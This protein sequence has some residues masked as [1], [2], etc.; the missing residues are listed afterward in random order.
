MT[1]QCRFDLIIKLSLQRGSVGERVVC[2]VRLSSIEVLC[3]TKIIAA[4]HVCKLHIKV[5]PVY[6]QSIVMFYLPTNV[7]LQVQ[8]QAGF[9]WLSLLCI[10]SCTGGFVRQPSWTFHN[11]APLTFYSTKIHRPVISIYLV[12]TSNKINVRSQAK[13]KFKCTVCINVPSMFNSADWFFFRL[14]KDWF[15]LYSVIAINIC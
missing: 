3:Y 6:T 5:W 12:G 7:K 8:T 9:L 10:M 14:S 15:T 13:Q 4:L 11:G 1:S 2:I